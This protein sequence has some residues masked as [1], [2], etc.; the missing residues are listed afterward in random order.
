M[1]VEL[2]G[3]FGGAG[4]AGRATIEAA[5]NADGTATRDGAATGAGIGAA[6]CSFA[7]PADEFAGLP[8]ER[9]RRARFV[10]SKFG[11]LTIGTGVGVAAGAGCTCVE[12]NVDQYPVLAGRIQSSGSQTNS[13]CKLVPVMPLCARAISAVMRFQL[14]VRRRS[15]RLR[16][17]CRDHV[18]FTGRSVRI[19]RGR[20]RR[21]RMARSR[22]ANRNS[23]RETSA[24]APD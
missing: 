23:L 21:I 1:I 22:M 8:N 15:N 19:H 9:R 18:N 13:P 10:S 6:A 12:S 3:G 4:V 2:G 16:A 5:F 17:C 20:G 24:S 11:G 7:S 14:R